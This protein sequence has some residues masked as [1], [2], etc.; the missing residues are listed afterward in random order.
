MIVG[1]VILS[2]EYLLGV[3]DIPQNIVSDATCAALPGRV[4]LVSSL[5]PDGG[6]LREMEIDLIRRTVVQC[7]GNESLAARQL[8]FSRKTLYEK[9]QRYEM[10]V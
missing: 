2:R 1:S 5:L 8:D 6:T 7:E 9:I 4:C 10:D 3:E